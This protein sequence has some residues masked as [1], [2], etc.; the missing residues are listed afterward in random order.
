M[1]TSIRRTC[2]ALGCLAPA[3][4][5]FAPTSLT[6]PLTLTAQSRLWINGTSTV[7]PFE[8][9]ASGVVAAADLT[10]PQLAAPF[11]AGETPV[12]AASLTV[13]ASA[14][15]CKNGTMNEHMRKALKVKENKSITFRISSYTVAKA[16]VG[17]TSTAKGELTLGGVTRPITVV[18]IATPG[19]DGA[20]HLVGSYDLKMTEWKIEPPKLMMGTMKVNPM[21]KVSFDLYLKS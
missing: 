18:G 2:I 13:P 17:S 21:V 19:A 8:C 3:I 20:L 4:L 6:A 10:A 7:R 11:L 9:S 1:R 5:A 16:A 15:D 14:L 12:N